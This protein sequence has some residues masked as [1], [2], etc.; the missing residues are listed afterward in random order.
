MGVLQSC[1]T[2]LLPDFV[3]NPSVLHW[4]R[5]TPTAAYLLVSMTN[6]GSPK[7]F[8]AGCT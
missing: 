7:T 3:E 4:S 2:I 6:R 8:K 5:N 1:V